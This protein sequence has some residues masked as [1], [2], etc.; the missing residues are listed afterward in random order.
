[1]DH[2]RVE[3]SN[4]ELGESEITANR[5]FHV[6]VLGLPRSGTSMMTKICELLGVNMIYTSE[7]PEKK[8]KMDERYKKTLG[9]KYHPNRDGFFEV[10]ENLF[11]H[12]LDV[13]ATPYSGCKMIIPVRR[14]IAD[15]MVFHPYSRVIQM[16][17][18]PEEIRQ[19]QQAFYRGDSMEEA[20]TRVAMLRTQLATQKLQLEKMGEKSGLQT[21]HVQYR[22][23]LASPTPI[24]EELADFINA[25]NDIGQ[26]IAHVKP[27]R[28]RF[29][30][31]D[32]VEGI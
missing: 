15:V 18:D 9:E 31:E 8:E 26:A 2:R 3:L 4:C 16:W 28:N 24:I 6:F 32:L 10:T 23:I 30:K 27:E 29:R 11:D 14:P 25:P 19:S 22:E 12:F 7:D 20:D 1:M 13:L 5:L 21:M 17:R